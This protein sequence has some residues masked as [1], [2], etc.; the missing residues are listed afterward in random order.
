MTRHRP[1]CVCV[2]L[3]T[4][5][6]QPLLSLS[7]GDQTLLLADVQF[8]STGSVHHT[9]LIAL[10][11]GRIWGNRQSLHQFLHFGGEAAAPVH[12]LDLQ[13]CQAEA[14]RLWMTRV[15]WGRLAW[16]DGQ[17]RSL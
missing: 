2:C 11:R 16:A 12:A 7:V 3:L 1:A 13:T 14:E 5:S 4:C 17:Y 6:V 10:Q 9:L 8:K 15:S